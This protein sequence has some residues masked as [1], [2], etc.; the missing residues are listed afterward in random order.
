MSPLD[1]RAVLAGLPKF[2]DDNLL[3]GM[4][5]SD[6]AGVYRLDDDT[7]LIQTV[8]FFTPIV[9]DPYTFGQISASNALSDIYA[10]GGKPLTA[11][12]MVCFPSKELPIDVLHKILEGGAERIKAAGAVLVGGHSIEDKEI[13]YGLSV[14][15]IISPKDIITNANAKPGDVLVLTKPIGTGLIA[16][17]IKKGDAAPSDVKEIV[18]S[19]IHLNDGGAELMRQFKASAA[20]DISGFGLLGH[21]FEMATASRVDLTIMASQ[22]PFFKKARKFAAQKKYL[23][24]GNKLNRQLIGDNII[25]SKAI[26]EDMKRLLYDPQTSGGLLIAVQKHR[27][28]ELVAGLRNYGYFSTGIIGFVS[29]GAGQIILG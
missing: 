7:A 24:K 26:D 25:I 28:D 6:D 12:N 14:T 10:M 18:Q 2:T 15:G 4:E 20:T 21:A 22:V 29:E 16:T 13:K 8:D 3:V 9:D 5:T 17:A 11:L 23:T 19:M 1:L 27:A